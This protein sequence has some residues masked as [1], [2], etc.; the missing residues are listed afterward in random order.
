[1]ALDPAAL[2]ALTAQW[3]GIKAELD[4]SE[5][6]TKINYNNAIDQLRRQNRQQMGTISVNA[7]DRGMTHSGIHG[8]TQMRQQDEFNRA[9]AKSAQQQQLALS[10]IARKRLQADAE[11]RAQQ[12]LL[13]SQSMMGV[14]A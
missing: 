7:S 8:Q 14:P 10:T 4:D 9:N 2:N 11:Y 13:Q 6:R 12:A 1:M 3:A 5:N